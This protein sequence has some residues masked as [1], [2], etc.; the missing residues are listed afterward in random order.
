MYTADRIYPV[1]LGVSLH[2]AKFMWLRC[3]FESEASEFTGAPADVFS[4]MKFFLSGR[5][6]YQC[7][8]ALMQ[9]SNEIFHCN[10]E[11]SPKAMY[12]LSQ[13][14]AQVN[15]RLQGDDAL[16]DSTIAIVM[17]LINQEQIRQHLSAAMIHVKGL[18]KM[19]ELRGGLS[20]LEGN[21][22]L[23]LKICK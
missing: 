14:F 6:A 4:F 20:Q 23:V 10:G 7:Q 8:L 11:S 19:I 15:K 2:E 21:V 22:P 13:T 16:S 5:V 9:A 17:S 1:K 3:L 12:H 18:E